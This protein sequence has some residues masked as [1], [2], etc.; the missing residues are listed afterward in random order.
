VTHIISSQIQFLP[1]IFDSRLKGKFRVQPVFRLGTG[2]QAM[3]NLKRFCRHGAN[4]N[5]IMHYV[6]NKTR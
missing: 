3:R 4:L 5:H 2:W 6:K 1:A